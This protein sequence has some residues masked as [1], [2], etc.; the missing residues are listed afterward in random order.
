VADKVDGGDITLS[1]QSG[2][3]LIDA[4][5]SKANDFHLS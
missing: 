4:V 1:D 3:D 5:L 2:Q